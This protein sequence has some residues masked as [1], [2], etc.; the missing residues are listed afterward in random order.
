M[1]GRLSKEAQAFLESLEEL[2]LSEQYS[3]GATCITPNQ[4]GDDLFE[5]D[6]RHKELINWSQRHIDTSKKIIEFIKETNNGK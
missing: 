6:Q 3:P 2:P 1:T 4:A 5:N